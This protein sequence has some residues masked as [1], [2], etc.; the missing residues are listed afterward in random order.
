MIIS[1]DI[2][3]LKENV[4]IATEIIAQNPENVQNV[5]LDGVGHTA[6]L[7]YAIQECVILVTDFNLKGKCIVIH[8]QRMCECK[9]P[10]FGV[11]CENKKIEKNSI[12]IRYS[13]Y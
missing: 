5:Y 2:V 13:N 1:D 10:Y 8:N 6:K 9:K 12:F 3:N 4:F 11:Y 7:W